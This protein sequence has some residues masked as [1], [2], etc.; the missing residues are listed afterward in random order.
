MIRS[1]LTA[2][3]WYFVFGILHELSHA[4]IALL[5][6]ESNQIN[7]WWK[8]INWR[9]LLL[10]RRFEFNPSLLH[11]IGD[12]N[13]SVFVIRHSGWIASV[14]IAFVLHLLSSRPIRNDSSD[15]SSKNSNFFKWCQLAAYMTAIDAVS[16]DLFQTNPFSVHSVFPTHREQLESTNKSTI[17]FFCGNFGVILLHSAW[18]YED[19]GQTTL[20][21]LRKMIEVTMMRGAQS[22]GIVTFERKNAKADNCNGVVEMKCTRSRVVKTKRGDL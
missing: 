4:F 18:L 10:Y 20:N 11:E 3:S 9:D 8:D 6:I 17:T 19:G 22:G 12:S 13:R 2:T 14:T 5:C 21:L 15:G 16:T 7:S 1:Y